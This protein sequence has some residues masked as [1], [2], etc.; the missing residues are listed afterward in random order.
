MADSQRFSARSILLLL[1]LQIATSTGAFAS[2]L[3]LFDF[4]QGDTPPPPPGLV[5]ELSDDLDPLSRA[6]LQQAIQAFSEN[7]FDETERRARMVTEN[8]PGAPEGWYVLG[9]AL[10][11]LERFDEALEALQRA[12]ELYEKNAGPFVVQGDILLALG[13][14][15]EARRAFE[16]AS[17]RDDADWRADVSLAQMAEADGDTDAAIRLYKRAIGKAPE[18]DL[19]TVFDLAELQLKSGRQEA[20]LSLLTNVAETSAESLRATV[21]LARAQR[22][23]G[24]PADAAV[25]FEHATRLDPDR[26]GIWLE[27]ADAHEAAGELNASLTTLKTAAGRFPDDAGIL[28]QLGRLHAGLREYEAAASAFERGLSISPDDRGLLKGA[29]MVRRRMGEVGPALELAQQLAE[30][31]DSGAED[32]LW[33]AIL[34]DQAGDQAG[35]AASYETALGIKPDMWLAANNLAVLLSK[36]DPPRAVMLAEA[37]LKASGGLAIVRETLAWALFNDGQNDRALAEFAQ[38]VDEDRD[39]PVYAFRNGLVLKA[40]GQAMAGRDE[41]QRALALDPDF[42]GAERARQLLDEQ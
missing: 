36:S 24:K 2:T 21:A 9:L 35:A 17:E 41:L 19:E 14:R 42:E 23:A 4:G 26:P 15:D 39:N 16:Q 33:L 6:A 3:E 20:A 11:N 5:V 32:H 8:V 7:R 13:R 30:R 25:T 18:G 40:A 31:E 22:I 28:L 38:V 29:S 1:A 34:R 12:G 37:A 27:L 10:A